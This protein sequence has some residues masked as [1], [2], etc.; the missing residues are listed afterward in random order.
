MKILR[1]LT[2][3]S[4]LL[5]TLLDGCS[6]GKSSYESGNYYQAV[7]TAVNRL[8]R[9]DDHKKSVETLRNAYPMAIF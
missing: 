4:L 7:I 1:I 3:G 2:L 9:N 5:I 8:R 6:S